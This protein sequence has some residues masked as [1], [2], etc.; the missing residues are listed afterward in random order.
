VVVEQISGEVCLTNVP[1]LELE[2]G[3]FSF[4]GAPVC[5]GSWCNRDFSL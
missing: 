3:A 5:G 1:R 4:G 2:S